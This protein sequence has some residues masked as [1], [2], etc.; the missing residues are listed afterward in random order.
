[1]AGNRFPE[2]WQQ[3]MERE[4]Q[5]SVDNGLAGA[6]LHYG[7]LNGM[8]YER[9]FGYQ[10][11]YNQTALMPVPE[12]M[13][14][15]TIFDLASLS[16]IFA[17][18]LALHKLVDSKTLSLDDTAAR[19]LPGFDTS[20]KRDLRLRD[21]LGHNAG[22]PGSFHF[23]DPAQ[24]GAAMYSQDR[25]RTLA[26]LGQVPLIN[27]PRTHTLY[28][29]LDFLTLGAV[30]EAVT[31]L[32]LD[33]Y[34][35]TEIYTP[36]GLQD[37]GYKLLEPDAVASS[38]VGSNLNNRAI[39]DF[40]ATERCGNTRDG[41]VSFPNI[42]TNTLQGQVHD[43]L[44]FYSMGQVSGHAGLF[45][46]AHDLGVLC[47][48]LLNGGSLGS[49]TLCSPQTVALFRQTFN[50]DQTY[51][52]GWELVTPATSLIFGLLAPQASK[53]GDVVAHTGWTGK[54]VMLDFVRGTYFVLLT[55]K[56]HSPVIVQPGGF[57]IFEGD[58]SPA[59]KYGN[60][61]DLYYGGLLAPAAS[62]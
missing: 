29:D 35:A 54:C 23:Y 26:L 45:S 43:E 17:T 40:S 4:L 6:V 5:T 38:H 16:K 53:L 18:L 12:P 46:T 56:K 19:Y 15:N 42:R 55:N 8:I 32:R 24:S 39:T 28:S 60:L 9:A 7:D 22:F 61:A 47:R 41:H 50:L 49:Y 30:I 33:H 51:A 44:S 34:L 59:A 25:A 58:L 20:E 37:I 21:F 1:M 62:M 31:G 10:R 27:P 52:L 48:L 2:L 13:R 3:R 57:N 11:R 36:L 14:S